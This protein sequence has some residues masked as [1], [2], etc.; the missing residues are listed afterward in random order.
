S[1]LRGTFFRTKARVP[2]RNLRGPPGTATPRST[3]APPPCSARHFGTPRAIAAIH[4]PP[5]IAAGLAAPC[6]PAPLAADSH[7][8]DIVRATR[9]AAGHLKPGMHYLIRW[10]GFAPHSAPH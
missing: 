9:F 2:G 1:P 8:P 10:A 7:A 6:S 3:G 4:R 5:N